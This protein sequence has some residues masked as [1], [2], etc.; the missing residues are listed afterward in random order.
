MLKT[1]KIKIFFK[2]TL[3]LTLYLKP[4]ILDINFDFIGSSS[5]KTKPIN[6]TIEI[7]EVIEY[8][9]PSLVEV[10]K[11][12]FKSRI[13][14]PIKSRFPSL[15][16]PVLRVMEGPKHYDPKTDTLI[17]NILIS[18]LNSTDMNIPSKGPSKAT[19]NRI[20]FD[21]SQRLE[22]ANTWQL[23]KLQLE[24]S[25]WL[26]KSQLDK[27][28][29]NK[30]LW[31]SK[32]QWLDKP[33]W[34]DKSQF[35]DKTERPDKYQLEKSQWMH[36]SHLEDLQCLDHSLAKTQIDKHRIKPKNS[37]E[38]NEST[39]VF[40]LEPIH[41]KDFGPRPSTVPQIFKDLAGKKFYLLEPHTV[42]DAKVLCAPKS[43]LRASKETTD[44]LK[45]LESFGEPPNET[46][47]QKEQPRASLTEQHRE[48]SRNAR[49]GQQREHVGDN[50][51]DHQRE[52]SRNAPREQQ[53]EHAGE[54]FREQQR[55]HLQDNFKEQQREYSTDK[56]REQQRAH[57]SDNLREQHRE[58]SRDHSKEKQKEYPYK[59][60][61]EYVRDTFGGHP[62]ESFNE[63]PSETLR[64][65]SK[66]TIS[67]HQRHHLNIVKKHSRDS[68]RHHKEL[69]RESS[70]SSTK[71]DK[72]L[73]TQVKDR[74][75]EQN[76]SRRDF[77]HLVP[78]KSEEV[79]LGELRKQL[80]SEDLKSVDGILITRGSTELPSGWITFYT[81][82][83][84][85][86]ESSSDEG[87]NLS[88]KD[89]K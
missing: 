56:L 24:D 45:E 43:I 31:M 65:Y 88:R 71:V 59:T 55:A 58:I 29:L 83:K 72:T 81:K 76:E 87:I 12:R 73:E 74:K 13:P 69:H 35:L 5:L 8:I 3:L 19:S 82:G 4:N 34:R 18:N 7:L 62:D 42:E 17:A 70:K 15:R 10:K 79:N 89:Y 6:K 21:G 47:G 53:R 85:M 75:Q 50:F 30:S 44:S 86:S 84:I 14:K 23:E 25:Q 36:R 1:V 78:D 57:P 37:K 40:K 28:N 64:K 32:S 41:N 68:S 16:K 48:H 67:E 27:S 77:S 60:F 38:T 51:R 63:Y 80:N 46:R 2:L 33:Q 52:Y 61:R 20:N 11:P 66:E 26:D 22:N 54:Y 49:R 9:S 39:N